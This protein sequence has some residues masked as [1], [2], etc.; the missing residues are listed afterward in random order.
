MTGLLNE[1]MT[2]FLVPINNENIFICDR[3]VSRTRVF[4][5]TEV[6]FPGWHVLS[7][8]VYHMVEI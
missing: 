4:E 1:L 3:K 8:V 7:S 6:L 2:G 5:Y